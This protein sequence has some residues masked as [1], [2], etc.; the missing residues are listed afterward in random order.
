M[1]AASN[2]NPW[3]PWTS[4]P[5]CTEDTRYCVFTNAGFQ[6]P[7]RGLSII[8]A[9]T[10]GTGNVTT[11][12]AFFAELLSSLHPAPETAEEKSPPYQVRDIPGKGKGIV[13]TRKISRGQVIMVDYAAVMADAR[14]PSRVKREQGRQ[15]LEEAIE[16]LPDAKEVLN[17]ARSS[18]DPDNVPVTEDVVK[19]NSFSV[20]IAGKE[21]M[22][23][24][25]RIARINHACKP[26]AL[27]H[28]NST[29]FSNTVTAFHDILPGKE[30]TISYS[31]FGLPSPARHK[32]L[33]AKWGFTCTCALCSSPPHAL[34]ASDAR[35]NKIEALGKEVVG[36]VEIGG[37]ADLKKAAELYA[38][39]VDAVKAE[40]LVPHL[41]GHYDVL[42]RLWAAAGEVEKGKGWILKG[43]KEEEGYERSAAGGERV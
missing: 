24:F 4:R 6:G 36:L 32:I 22:A 5:F 42:G 2:S 25:P 16:R 33:L 18:S 17:L 29:A 30:I 40:G 23:L 19:T 11:A 20:N 28:F 14:F 7:N 21:Y 3:A 38:E 8:D 12:A 41:G 43:R 39:V 37:T 31:P 35:R 26:S 9:P 27:T 15:L 1:T 10:D 34:A 13:A